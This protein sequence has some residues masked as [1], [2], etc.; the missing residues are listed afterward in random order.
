[1]KTLRFRW[2]ISVGMVAMLATT[3]CTDFLKVEN[4]NTVTATD[5][6]PVTDAPTLAASALQDF[7]AAYGT[8][9]VFGGIFSGELYSA[10]VNSPGNLFSVRRV[11]ETMTNG[12]LSSMSKAR[13]LATKVI[14]ALKGSPAE[15]SVNAA[16]AWLVSGY[17]FLVMSDHFCTIAVDGGP[18]LTTSMML[19]SVVVNLTK[20]ID[21]AGALTGSDAQQ[22]KNTALV[23]R[24]R[25]YLQSGKKSLAVTDA[26]AVTAGFTYN[27]T[28]INDLSNIQRLGNYV[29]Y[30]EFAIGTLSA[31]PD[32]RNSSDP[33]IVTVAP[34]VNKLKPM[35]SQTDVWSIGKYPGYASPVRLASKLEADYIAAEATG[36]A[37]MLTLIQ[38]RRAASGQP[39]YTGGTDDRSV[40][41]EFLK[42]RTYE[43]YVEGKHMGDL[44]RY[45]NDLPFL[46]PTGTPYR[47]ANVPSY[48]DGVCWPISIQ[49]KSNNPNFAKP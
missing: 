19:D 38:A 5:V 18:E 41:V 24:A 2:T 35:D 48:A 44:R 22:I 29:W 11:D 1:M 40:L 49:E 33:R 37:A 8:Y 17:A 20:A 21:L 23:G 32:F 27:L 28:F 6:N 46:V 16:K 14:A 31:A 9:A 26:N 39:A 12:F 15:T 43:F 4:P 13:V 34:A 36:T 25:A 7:A 10:D 47:K 3:G 42:Q 45:P 30:I